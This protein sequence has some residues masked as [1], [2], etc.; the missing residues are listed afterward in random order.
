MDK[1]LK[2]PIKKAPVSKNI[3]RKLLETKAVEGAK[4]ALREYKRVF[5]RLAEFDRV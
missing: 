1:T 3:D 4:K 5:E 2:N